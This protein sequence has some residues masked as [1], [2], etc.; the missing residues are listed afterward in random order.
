LEAA[1]PVP[2]DGGGRAIRSIMSVEN[3]HIFGSSKR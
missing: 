1:I 3:V 2:Y